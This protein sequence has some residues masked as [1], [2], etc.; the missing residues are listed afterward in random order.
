MKYMMNILYS[1]DRGSC[2]LDIY[3]KDKAMTSNHDVR[4]G[5]GGDVIA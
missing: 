5:D 4:D 2:Q 3:L 1:D